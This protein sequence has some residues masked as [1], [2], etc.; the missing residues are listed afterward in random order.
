MDR[1]WAFINHEYL[2]IVNTRFGLLVSPKGRNLN[3]VTKLDIHLFG[4][5]HITEEGRKITS[6]PTAKC[7]SLLAFLALHPGSGHPRELLGEFLWPEASE[8]V[9]RTR[10]NVTLH[11]LKKHLES[12][13][14]SLTD[15]IESDRDGIRLNPVGIRIDFADFIEASLRAER[16]A[17][18]EERR[19][20]WQQ[21]SLLYA[22]PL[23]TGL[24]EPFLEPWRVSARQTYVEAVLNLATEARLQ[25]GLN[26]ALKFFH[27]ALRVEGANAEIYSAMTNWFAQ[28]SPNVDDAKASADAIAKSLRKAILRTGLPGVF[29]ERAICSVLDAG[30]VA[31][32]ILGEICAHEEA[33]HL[34]GQPRAAFASPRV[35][36]AVARKLQEVVPD[37]QSV[38][39]TREV[40]LA[41]LPDWPTPEVEGLPNRAILVD[42]VSAMLLATEESKAQLKRVSDE[43]FAVA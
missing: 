2:P 32:T 14:S 7:R 28:A 41:D 38:V 1:N 43:F 40:T 13:N 24:N 10:L 5:V 19:A 8:D 30:N 17:D 4:R 37:A 21:I 35:A 26:T 15:H 36:I 25:H 6:F 29:P 20:A 34:K 18:E 42:E 11:L 27:Q 16:T 31:P 39:R 23:A 3:Q 22:G 12:E 33:L 9:A